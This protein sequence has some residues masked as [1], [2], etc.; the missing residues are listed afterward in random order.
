MMTKLSTALRGYTQESARCATAGTIPEKRGT[1]DVAGEHSLCYYS[2]TIL[3]DV[4]ESCSESHYKTHA[5]RSLFGEGD[6]TN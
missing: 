3:I 2:P 1:F 5:N 6:N 4:L